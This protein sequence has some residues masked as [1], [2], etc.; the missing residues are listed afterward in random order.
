MDM[1]K[2]PNSTVRTKA[3]DALLLRSNTEESKQQFRKLLEQAKAAQLKNAEAVVKK[4][5]PALSQIQTAHAAWDVKRAEVLKLIHTDWHKDPEKVAMLS[6]EHAETA[7]RLD[8]LG[9]A[10]KTVETAWKPLADSTVALEDM[11]RYLALLDR[12]SHAPKSA[13]DHLKQLG[14]AQEAVGIFS[15]VR[16]C[17][18]AAEDLSAAEAHNAA[19]KGVPKTAVMFATILNQRRHVVGLQPLWLDERLS[20]AAA[21]HSQEMMSLGYFA[22]ESPVEKNKTPWMRGRNA[23]FDGSSSGECI[24]M[25]SAAPE[26]AYSAWWGSDG[27]RFILFGAGANTLGMGPVGNHWTLMTGVKNRSRLAVR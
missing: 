17:Q 3:L 18:R 19:L 15:L 5:S 20:K 4:G 24:Y 8:A 21:D 1:L 14:A 23:G 22:H 6:R 12:N 11:D 25:G 2:S 13:E 27:H 16:Q 7:A 26:A 10:M 9:K